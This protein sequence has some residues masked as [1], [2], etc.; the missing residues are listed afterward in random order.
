MY[1]DIMHRPLRVLRSKHGSSA[2]NQVVIYFN[3]RINIVH[4][5]V[6]SNR[7]SASCCDA[8]A[9][10]DSTFSV[11]IGWIIDFMSSRN[12][13]Y[14]SSGT[15][16]ICGDILHAACLVIRNKKKQTKSSR[17]VALTYSRL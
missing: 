7:N 15:R 11:R 13:S 3:Q 4:I 5:C 14:K 9:V 2:V 8:C 12:N 17:S 10:A 6:R 1:I 16:F